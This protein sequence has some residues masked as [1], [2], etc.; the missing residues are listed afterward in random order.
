MEKRTIE[1]EEDAV[2][3]GDGLLKAQLL[4]EL[5]VALKPCMHTVRR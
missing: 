3:V 1:E 4:P 5:L 2:A